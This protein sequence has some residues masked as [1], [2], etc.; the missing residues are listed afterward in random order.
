VLLGRVAVAHLSALAGGK[1]APGGVALAYEVPPKPEE[2]KEGVKEEE[3]D[4]GPADVLKQGLR[5]AKL[6]FLKVRR[7]AR[8]GV[9]PLDGPA[10]QHGARWGRAVRTVEASAPRCE[11]TPLRA[12]QL[13]RA[14]YFRDAQASCLDQVV[15]PPVLL[16]QQSPSTF[17]SHEVLF[18]FFLGDASWFFALAGTTISG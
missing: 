15:P 3:P 5:E 16:G 8:G 7:A 2:R 11:W 10:R 12:Q 9:F 1:E 14:R 17:C 18:V 4:K 13:K 6:K